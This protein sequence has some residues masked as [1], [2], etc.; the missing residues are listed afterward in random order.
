MAEGLRCAKGDVMNW[1][2]HADLQAEV[3]TGPARDWNAILATLGTEIGV[4]MPATLRDFLVTHPYGVNLISAEFRP[5][6]RTPWDDKEGAQSLSCLLGIAGPDSVQR[7]VDGVVGE[8]IPWLLPIG[9]CPGGNY[10]CYGLA[11]PYE[12]RLWFWDHEHDGITNTDRLQGLYPAAASLADLLA[13]LYR[14]PDPEL[15]SDLEGIWMADE[16]LP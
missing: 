7:A 9:E 6:E 1:T 5:I 16:L 14:L 3:R 12:D 8:V 11:G 15:D 13:G 10:L 2:F 4:E